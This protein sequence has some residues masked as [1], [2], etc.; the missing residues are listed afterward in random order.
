MI[1]PDQ[2]SVVASLIKAYNRGYLHDCLRSILFW[3]A[4]SLAA[5]RH[6]GAEPIRETQSPVTSHVPIEPPIGEKPGTATR[7]SARSGDANAEG[8]DRTVRIKRRSPRYGEIED[9]RRPFRRRA[10]I[11]RTACRRYK[12]L[13]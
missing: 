10:D 4:V 13:G 7:T 8:V 9:V 11:L 2:G 1:S 3:Q 6:P 12:T 5:G